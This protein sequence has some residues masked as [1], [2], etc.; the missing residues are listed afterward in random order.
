MSFQ[1]GQKVV[2]L[3]ENGGGVIKEIS[4]NGLFVVED[5]DG[6]DRK[7]KASQLAL[8]HGEHGE[9]GEIG[10]GEIEHES[11]DFPKRQ[12]TKRTSKEWL[13][14]L[15]IETLIEDHSGMSNYDILKLQM[16]RLR[17]FVME[18]Q[19]R[20]VR[21]IVVVHGVGEGVLKHEVVTYFKGIPGT[22]TFDGNYWEYGQG[23]TVAILR[24]KY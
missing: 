13:I 22:E 21:R 11:H 6:F 24:Y 2:F 17:S 7:Y 18:A 12:S 16:N 14:D 9:I 3:H 1:I 19:D 5:E 23:A 20:M 4:S 8:V 10:E 15:H